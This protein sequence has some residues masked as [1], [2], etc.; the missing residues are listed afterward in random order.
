MPNVAQLRTGSTTLPPETDVLAGQVG[1][2]EVCDER[3][4]NRRVRGRRV[5][6]REPLTP[7]LPD[8]DLDLLQA[9]Q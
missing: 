1:Q 4:T 8:L 6:A 3:G 2:A 9:A 5:T 7:T